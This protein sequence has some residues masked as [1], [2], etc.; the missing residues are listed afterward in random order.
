MKNDQKFEK[1]GKKVSVFYEIEGL[2][3]SER[4]IVEQMSQKVREIL[5]HSRKDSQGDIYVVVPVDAV[6][7]NR[8]IKWSKPVGDT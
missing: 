7:R 1:R 8:G 4:G 3:G 6:K 5:S 2:Q